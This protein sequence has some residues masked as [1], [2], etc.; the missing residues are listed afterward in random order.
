MS[1][2]KNNN[3][4]VVIGHFKNIKDRLFGVR[5]QKNTGSV[6]DGAGSEGLSDLDSL[7][8]EIQFFIMTFLSPQDLCKLGGTSRYWRALSRDPSMWR[9]FLLRHLPLWSSIDHLSMPDMVQKA[10]SESSDCESRDY[11]ADYL[12][13]CPASR[14]QWQRSRPAYESVTSF[15]KS[16]VVMHEPRFA[17]FGPG[18]E[19]LEVSL[20]TTMLNSP[21]ILPVTGVTQRQIDGIGSGISFLYNGQHKFNVLTLY[22]ANRMERERARLEHVDTQSRLFTQSEDPQTNRPVLNLVPTVQEVCQV[23]DGFIFVTNAERGRDCPEARKRE[24]AQISA[25]LASTWGPS[26]R[27][28]LVLACTARG[29]PD[30]S[31]VPCVTIAQSL[32]LSLLANPWKVQDTVSE[33]LEGLLDGIL[34]ILRQTGM[35]L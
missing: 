13:A 33:S 22:S 4:F 9:Y 11:M 35:R 1:T 7:P 19:Q 18:L 23:V 14:G 24:F 26:S 30:G 27:P 2:S 25:M 5:H 34:W 10:L 20:V 3:E 28:L 6:D 17:M 31:R 16:M 32:Q 15:L 21:E 12:R 29:D 8:V